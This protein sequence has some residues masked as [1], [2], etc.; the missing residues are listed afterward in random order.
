MKIFSGL[1]KSVTIFFVAIFFITNNSVAQNGIIPFTGIKYFSEGVTIKNAEVR[2]NGMTLLNNRVPL[3]KEIEIYLQQ[4]TGFT[5]N[6]KKIIFAAAEVSILSSKGDVLFA[7]PNV[8][9][10]NA[11]TGF[12]P[13]DFATPVIK[14][15]ITSQ[16]IKANTS[17]TI[18]I[19]LYDLNSKSQ[20][21]LEFAVNITRPG[22]ALLLSKISK[23]IKTPANV[24]TFINDIKVAGVKVSVDTTIKTNPKMAYLAL[25]ILKIDGSS[26]VGILGGKEEFWVYD[27]NLNSIKTAEILLKEVKGTME[28]STVNYNLKIP[29]RLKT[30]V[31]KGYIIRFRWHSNDLLQVI[32]VV[33]TL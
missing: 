29:F 23:P 7:N 33:V 30:A 32:D 15:N 13:K 12:T 28:G 17:A 6:A 5:A 31:E 1:P 25:D 24:T 18:K 4:P 14:C 2:L 20:L 21:R 26:F 8:L 22:E 11:T 9:A 27:K 10:A 19:R 3:N 16:L